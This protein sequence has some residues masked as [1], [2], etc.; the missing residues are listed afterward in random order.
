MKLRQ[1]IIYGSRLVFALMLMIAAGTNRIYAQEV[2]TANADSIEAGPAV[3]DSTIFI[4]RMLQKAKVFNLYNPQEKVYMHFDNTGYFKGETMRFKAYVIRCDTEERTDLSGVLYVELINPSGDVVERRKLKINNGEAEGDIKVDSIQSTGFYE[5]RAYTRWMT[6]WGMH[7]CFSRVFPIFKAPRQLGDYSRQEL[8]MHSYSKRL[9]NTRV[10]DEGLVVE[11]YTRRM[12]MKFY[13]EGGDLVEGLKSRVAFT[14]TDDAGG[15]MTTE[16]WVEDEKKTKICTLKTDSR[17]R[18]I[19]EFTPQAGH[20]YSAVVTTDKDKE[21]RFPLPTPRQDGVVLNVNMLGEVDIEATLQCSE[22]MH[23]RLLGYAL[24]HG[25]TIIGCDTLTAG[26]EHHLAFNRFVQPD[27][28]NQLTIF[29]TNGEILA[30]RLIFIYPNPT[31][32]DSIAISSTTTQLV[33]CGK[34]TFKIQTEPNSSVSFSAIDAATMNNGAVGNMKTWMLL[35]SEVRGYIPNPEYYFESD[36]EEHRRQADLLMMIQGW[37]RYDFRLMAGV[38][39]MENRQPIEDRLYLFGQV[40]SKLKR[41]SPDDVEITAYMYNKS[42][43]VIDGTLKT[44]SVGKYVYI[45]PDVEGDWMLQLESKKNDEAQNYYIGI[46][47]HF[48]PEKRYL[49]ADETQRLPLLA[50]N[51]EPRAAVADED[52]DDPSE[53][54]SITQRT[55]LLPTVKV[56]T[57]RLLGDLKSSWYDETDAQRESIIRYD[58]DDDADSYADR[59]E[60]VPSFFKWFAEKNPFFEYE[61]VIFDDPER[62]GYT[63]SSD[64][65]TYNNRPII[66]I[67]D[68]TFWGITGLYDSQITALRQ[69]GISYTNNN[70]G[71]VMIPD[72]LDV[73]KTVYISEDL[74]AIRPYLMATGLESYNPVVVYV[75]E[76]P[77]FWF[78]KKGLRRTHF[79]GFNVPTAFEMED[80]SVMPPTEDFR[81]TLYWDANVKTDNRGRATVEFYNNSSCKSMF[82]SAEGMTDD[83]HILVNQ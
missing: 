3:A 31:D 11:S 4:Q 1:D 20:T 82:I 10:D 71:N 7:A 79:E 19:F 39:E 55:H 58:C 80:Y 72:M 15:Y 70:T 25:G 5:V 45:V 40:K 6:N 62:S 83:G 28:V 76:H 73:A 51:F 78:K 74:Q 18:G 49:Y 21:R 67:I 54:V 24:M 29:G 47:R 50:A 60:E 42:G 52:I 35:S 8:D 34:V 38:T 36:D 37:R 27:G 81:R 44:D 12:N 59:G 61:Q 53:Y 41:Y 69:D 64:R 16:G 48:S 66:W 30:E 63:L 75:Y 68:N 22:G 56:R 13:P 32:R 77:L 43:Q 26:K 33:P 9:P 2:V 14:A 57:R 17:G 23:G 46:D 65:T